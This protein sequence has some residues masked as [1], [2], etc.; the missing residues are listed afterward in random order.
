[1]RV[2]WGGIGLLI[3]LLILF[4]A[5]YIPKRYM[6]KV[7]EDSEKKY[8]EICRS[9]GRYYDKDCCPPPLF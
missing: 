7:I 8:C 2:N 5:V 1:M 3:I 6:K 4:M 9:S